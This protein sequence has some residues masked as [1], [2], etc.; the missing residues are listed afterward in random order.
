M[1]FVIRGDGI[2]R[3]DPLVR[4]SDAVTRTSW[5]LRDPYQ[6]RRVNS[7]SVVEWRRLAAA[8]DGSRAM[9]WARLRFGRSSVLNRVARLEAC[10]SRTSQRDAEA[11]DT[12][13]AEEAEESALQNQL[14]VG[15]TPKPWQTIEM[16]GGAF[17]ASRRTVL[18]VSFACRKE[19]R[20]SSVCREMHSIRVRSSAFEDRLRSKPRLNLRRGALVLCTSAVQPELT[21][22]PRGWRGPLRVNSGI[23]LMAERSLRAN[24]YCRASHSKLRPRDAFEPLLKPEPSRLDH[25]HFGGACSRHEPWPGTSDIA[26][27]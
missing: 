20:G 15:R 9:D 25:R 5:S 4:I 3:Q 11:T 12:G 24:F 10:T 19:N 26:N 14:C 27:T 23:G 7:V 21:A 16:N 8:R 18:C 2:E 22:A 13:A 17:A 6:H 1:E